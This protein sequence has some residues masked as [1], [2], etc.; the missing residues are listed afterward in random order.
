MYASW[1]LKS[2]SGN[3][4]WFWWGWNGFRSRIGEYDGGIGLELDKI[5]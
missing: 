1:D 2:E 5:V 4:L 3:V